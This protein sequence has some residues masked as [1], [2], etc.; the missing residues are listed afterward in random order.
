MR[1]IAVEKHFTCL[2]LLNQIDHATLVRN[3]WPAPG[4][5]IYQAIHPPALADTGHERIAAMDT[6][7]IRMQVL[8]VSG[9]GPRL[10]QIWTASSLAIESRNCVY[11]KA[12][13]TSPGA[14][15]HCE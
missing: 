2:D 10:S 13:L 5:P 9:R 7:G 6:A 1:I 11:V 3:G 15:Y 4:T 14:T 12:S 8:S